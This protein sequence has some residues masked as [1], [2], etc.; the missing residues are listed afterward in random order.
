MFKL[1]KYQRYEVIVLTMLFVILFC[2]ARSIILE[3]SITG[4]NL[5]ITTLLF[6]TWYIA[7]KS[8]NNFYNNV[9]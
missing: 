7:S 5:L 2:Y 6:A 9:N 1:T 8:T 3:E 4:K